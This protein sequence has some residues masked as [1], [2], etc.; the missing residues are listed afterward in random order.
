MAKSLLAL[1]NAVLRQEPQPPH[2]ELD[3]LHWDRETRTW[4]RHAEPDDQKAA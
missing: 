3:H 4:R 1:M 2:A